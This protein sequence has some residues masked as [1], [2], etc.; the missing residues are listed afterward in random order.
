MRKEN[1]VYKRERRSIFINIKKYLLLF[2]LSLASLTTCSFIFI[3]ILSGQL[4]QSMPGNL[5][6]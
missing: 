3:Y 6:H 4:L 5:H 1:L 2:F